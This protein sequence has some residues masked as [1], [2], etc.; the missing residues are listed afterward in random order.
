[1]DINHKFTPETVKCNDQVILKDDEV[2]AIEI[3]EARHVAM[4][5]I[6]QVY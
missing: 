5:I 2:C 4:G 3:C 6:P 1:M